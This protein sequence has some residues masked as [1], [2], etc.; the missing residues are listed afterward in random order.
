[1]NAFR[2]DVR[3]SLRCFA[4]GFRFLSCW[5]CLLQRRSLITCAQPAPRWASPRRATSGTAPVAASPGHPKAGFRREYR[6][7]SCANAA[8]AIPVFAIQD[9]TPG[10]HW[11]GL[12]SAGRCTGV[13]QNFGHDTGRTTDSFG[14]GVVHTRWL[15]LASGRA[16]RRQCRPARACLWR[17]ASPANSSQA[18]HLIRGTWPPL[19]DGAWCIG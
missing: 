19:A 16:P 6:R 4:S 3:C 13:A 15:P 9:G 14:L 17:S 8:P 11:A 1:M 7:N 12:D 10:S 18:R 5:G 2:I